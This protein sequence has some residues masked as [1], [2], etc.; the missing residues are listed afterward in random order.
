MYFYLLFANTMCFLKYYSLIII[1]DN[2]YNGCLLFLNVYCFKFS[3]FWLKS[4]WIYKSTLVDLVSDTVFNLPEIFTVLS[5]SQW[6]SNSHLILGAQQADY[7]PE[8]KSQVIFS[9]YSHSISG[10]LLIFHLIKFAVL[11]SLFSMH[12]K[13]P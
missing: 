4:H 1:L 5:D 11:D 9:S 6:L 12:L 3:L 13:I 10:S 8:K 2:W 7:L